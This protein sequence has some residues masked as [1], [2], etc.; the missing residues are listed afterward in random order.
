MV[1]LEFTCFSAPGVD[2]V[3]D[4]RLLLVNLMF[5]FISTSLLR[6]LSSSDRTG[7]NR[8]GV[9]R[10]GGVGIMSAEACSAGDGKE[11]SPGSWAKRRSKGS[12]LCCRVSRIC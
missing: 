8:R 7:C 2:H 5:H 11:G 12:S 9:G 3:E 6:P 1:K 10:V 4:K